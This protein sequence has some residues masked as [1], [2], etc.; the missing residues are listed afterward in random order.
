MTNLKNQPTFFDVLSV[1]EIKVLHEYE[2]YS[3]MY[4][5][6]TLSSQL[7]RVMILQEIIQTTQLLMTGF[8]VTSTQK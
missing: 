5:F 7:V 2:I 1:I 6:L 4:Y 3:Y 8:S